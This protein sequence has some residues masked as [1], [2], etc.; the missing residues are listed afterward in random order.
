MQPLAQGLQRRPVAQFG[1]VDQ[2]EGLPL[3]GGDGQRRQAHQA[4]RGQRIGGQQFAH[5]RQ[6]Q[7]LFG[8]LGQH[9]GVVEQRDRLDRGAHAGRLE[10]RLPQPLF[11]QQRLVGQPLRVRARQAPRCGRSRHQDHARG[12]IEQRLG[13]LAGPGPAPEA[14]GGVKALAVQVHDLLRGFDLQGDV[15]VVRMP[16]RHAWQQPQLCQRRQDRNAQAQSGAGRCCGGG[17]DAFVQQRQGGLGG[18]QQRL[19]GGI[20]HQA[21]R[22]AI[23]QRE[24]QLGFQ[25]ADLL[26]DGAVRQMQLQRRRAQVLQVGDDAEHG[27]DIQGQAARTGKHN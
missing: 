14:Q 6:P 19:P 2:V 25:R 5:Q 7:V 15:R 3:L 9:A 27:Q 16:A 18:A 4:A 17:L 10:P 24:A 12:R 13:L 21:A 20:E 23:E 26:A 11:S 1:P 22:T 8:R